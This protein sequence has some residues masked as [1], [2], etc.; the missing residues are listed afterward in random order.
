MLEELAAS[1]G[2]GYVSLHYTGHGQGTPYPSRPNVRVQ[3]VTS[4][5]TW[6]NDIMDVLNA[7]EL[8]LSEDQ[9]KSRLVLV[10]ASL[11]GWL[12]LLVLV[13]TWHD[14][15]R[16]LAQMV[17]GVVLVAPAIDASDRWGKLA[18][19]KHGEKQSTMVAVPSAYLET[20][21][22]HIFLHKDLITGANKRFLL[23]QSSPCH[24]KLKEEPLSLPVHIL[25]G[26]HDDVIGVESLASISTSGVLPNATL[27]RIEGGDHRLSDEYSLSRIRHAV[28]MLL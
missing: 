27:E 11:G 3:D 2:L 7:R 13:A 9:N 17:D 26:T 28:V 1:Q 10:G 20:P 5:E 14:K 8:I 25:Y 24:S 18:S 12:A 19:L 15:N 22:T 23:L 6:C 16:I 4:L 21:D